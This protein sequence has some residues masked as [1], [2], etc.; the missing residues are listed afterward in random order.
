MF[1]YGVKIFTCSQNDLDQLIEMNSGKLAG[2]VVP[3]GVGITEIQ[4]NLDGETKKEPLEMLFCGSIEYLPNKEGLTWFCKEVFPLV[5]AKL[6]DAKLSIVG[7]GNPGKELS[8]LLKSSSIFNHGGVERINTYYQRASIA[9]VPLLSGS[10]TRLKLMEAMAFKVPVVSTS[11]GAE[12]IN[13]TDRKNILI[14]D[15]PGSFANEVIE[16][17]QNPQ[18]ANNIAN[19]AFLLVKNEYDWDIVGDKMANYLESLYN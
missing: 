18:L 19:E 3:N 4:R 14:A 7:R 17:L 11:I 8:D 12:G 5:L 9:I 6:P 15:S 13:Y 10:G 2:V 16:L 1:K